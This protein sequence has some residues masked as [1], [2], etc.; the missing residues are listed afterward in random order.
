MP[1]NTGH[2][3]N[4]ESFQFLH[5]EIKDDLIFA[6]RGGRPQ[7]P[8]KYQLA[9][10]LLRMGAQGAVCTAGIMAISEGS[11]YTYVYRV[12]KAFRNVR[13]KHLAWPG[14]ERR[15]FLSTAME[16]GWGFP[17]CIGIGDGSYIFLSDKPTIN[18]YAYWCRK[19]GYAVRQ[20]RFQ[21]RRDLV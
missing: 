14:A 12:G 19:K 6:A 3:V 18:G 13:D 11:T 4:R 9:T 20:L 7:L 17:G 2:S 1:A 21:P 15:D 10:F 8:V 5:D 16:E